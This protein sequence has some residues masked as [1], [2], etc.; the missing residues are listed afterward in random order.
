MNDRRVP[1]MLALTT[2]RHEL[3]A[4][5]RIRLFFR[6]HLLSTSESYG[7]RRRYIF[8]VEPAFGT[9]ILVNQSDGKFVARNGQG[10]RWHH[11]R[12]DKKR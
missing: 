3:I 7:I 2:N 1:G 6:K 12:Q 10:N 11:R 8:D 9:W 5:P 4:Q